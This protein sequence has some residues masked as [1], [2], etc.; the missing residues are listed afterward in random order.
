VKNRIFALDPARSILTQDKEIRCVSGRD[1]SRVVLVAIA[2]FDLAVGLIVKLQDPRIM[3]RQVHE[4]QFIT[5]ALKLDGASHFLA[6]VRST[7][8]TS[9]TLYMTSRW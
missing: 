9:S 5:M 8:I 2:Q 6:G 1:I 3:F 4:R 7:H